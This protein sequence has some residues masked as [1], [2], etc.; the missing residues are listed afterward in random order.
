MSLTE[1]NPIAFHTTCDLLRRVT[2]LDSRGGLLENY[3]VIDSGI[4]SS[5]RIK[6]AE[7]IIGPG[8]ALNSDKLDAGKRYVQKANIYFQYE[9]TTQP[10]NGDRVL[11]NTSGLTYDVISVETKWISRD[12]ATQPHHFKLIG[13]LYN[14]AKS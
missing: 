9:G 11:D 4:P 6:T 2:S 10:L 14:A 13:V 7:E 12:I 5:V 3:G 1:I 8:T